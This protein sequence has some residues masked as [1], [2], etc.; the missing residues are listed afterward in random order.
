VEARGVAHLHATFAFEALR[1]SRFMATKMWL[2]RGFPFLGYL[3][4]N[5]W[6]W[7]REPL[8]SRVVSDQID[9][10]DLEQYINLRF[11]ALRLTAI[12]QRHPHKLL[13]SLQSI[14]ET[15]SAGSVNTSER[16]DDASH[17]IIQE[18]ADGVSRFLRSTMRIFKQCVSFTDEVSPHDFHFL[19]VLSP[20]TQ[21]L[22]GLCAEILKWKGPQKILCQMMRTLRCTRRVICDEIE[23][24]S[25]I[26]IELSSKSPFLCDPLSSQVDLARALVSMAQHVQNYIIV[27]RSL[28]QHLV[29]C[30]GLLPGRNGD[31]EDTRNAVLFTLGH[32]G[33]AEHPDSLI[34]LATTAIFTALTLSAWISGSSELFC[35]VLS[36]MPSQHISKDASP[37]QNARQERRVPRDSTTEPCGVSN[38]NGHAH[39]K[40]MEF[41]LL[42]Y[43]VDVSHEGA[44]YVLQGSEP[45]SF[46]VRNYFTMDMKDDDPIL[47]LSYVEKTGVPSN[48][49]R[50]A[51]IRLLPNGDFMFVAE[52][53]ECDKSPSQ[54]TGVAPSLHLLLLNCSFKLRFEDEN[55]MPERRPV[56]E[57]EQNEE[58]S[59]FDRYGSALSGCILCV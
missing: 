52:G 12:H 50:H 13:K 44:N 59:S 18:D 34:G 17:L 54:V 10:K 27:S 51:P 30:M 1:D 22:Y 41:E 3:E 5:S 32:K 11:L 28:V 48:I 14:T 31:D 19:S 42:P 25:S 53:T 29:T 9:S 33:V 24:L 21:F 57:K 16:R 8:F 47:V 35:I 55:R 37:L 20:R 6:P 4:F 7:E 45:G 43:I 26:M 39:Y 38:E 56:R 2:D 36:K 49:V 15:E 58:D 23:H 46:L 40:C